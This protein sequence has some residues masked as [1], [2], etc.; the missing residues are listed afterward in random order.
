MAPCPEVA[1]RSDDTITRLGE[2]GTV[3]ADHVSDLVEVSHCPFN[4]LVLASA[5]KDE[6]CV[7]EVCVARSAEWLPQDFMTRVTHQGHHRANE[8]LYATAVR[9]SSFIVPSVRAP[10]GPPGHPPI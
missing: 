2:L 1:R 5:C 8:V 7:R 3:H 10:G 4:G 6:G 9:S